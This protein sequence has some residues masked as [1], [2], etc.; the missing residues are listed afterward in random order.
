MKIYGENFMSEILDTESRREEKPSD[1]KQ[2]VEKMPLKFPSTTMKGEFRG[3]FTR[4]TFDPAKFYT[5]VLM[6][7]GRVQLD[8]DW[9]EQ[10]DILLHYLRALAA[11][12]IGPFGGQCFNAG[13][14]IT[15]EDSNESRVKREN[16]VKNDLSIGTGHYYVDGI[17][18]V[19]KN[20]VT[21]SNQRDYPLPDKYAMP[22]PP[23]LVY[24]DVWERTITYNEDSNIRETALGINGPDT[25][26]RS[27][28]VWQVKIFSSCDIEER[29]NYN[30]KLIKALPNFSGMIDCKEVKESWKLMNQILRPLSTGQLKAEARQLPNDTEPCNI[31]PESRYHRAENQLY[32]VEIHTPGFA[33]S[34]D[35]DRSCSTDVATFKWSRENSSVTFPII[36]LEE[37]SATLV[38]LGRDDWTTLLPGDWVEIIDD[39]HILR[40][41]PGDILQIS[42]VERL[43]MTVTFND[44]TKATGYKTKTTVDPGTTFNPDNYKDSNHH[45]NKNLNLRRW[46]Y[47]LSDNKDGAVTVKEVDPDNKKENFIHLEDGV[48]IQFQ[49]DG[50]YNTGD[51]WLIPARTATGD[52]IWPYE[53]GSETE[54]KYLLPHGIEHHYAPL[55]LVVAGGGE[56]EY[57]VFDCRCFFNRLC[58]IEKEKY[59]KI[60]KVGANIENSTIEVEGITNL[61]VGDTILWTVLSGLTITRSHV[62]VEPHY[63]WNTFKFN[64]DISL[65]EEE[66]VVTVIALRCMD[67]KDVYFQEK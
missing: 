53:D 41:E 18:C 25:A 7:Q 34:S 14:E 59:I 42:F 54:R 44:K 5:R 66:F 13:F 33:Y 37:N 36:S 63:H 27:Q 19:N 45:I 55:A 4:D 2:S 50:Y 38:H 23:F 28:L 43:T 17:L 40:E 67:V 31:K 15:K 58:S 9:N 11:D 22:E 24:L 60:T 62:N 30:P 39:N 16:S 21:Y 10:A 51:Y 8:A 3:D 35:L 65:L 46:D 47:K 29:K 1:H 12:L 26:T 52:V 64:V 48:Q 20:P 56:N 6:Q 57:S 49:K 32:R 61:S